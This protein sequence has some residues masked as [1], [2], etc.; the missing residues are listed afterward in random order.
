AGAAQY[1]T[2]RQRSEQSLDVLTAK[3]HQRPA[4]VALDWRHELPPALTSLFHHRA[5]ETLDVRPDGLQAHLPQQPERR[6]SRVHSRHRRR[7]GLEAARSGRVVEAVDVI[8]KRVLLS[9]PAAVG[10]D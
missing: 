9:E 3:H 7:A 2:L 10:R 6:Q 4:L 1:L 8:R 5:D